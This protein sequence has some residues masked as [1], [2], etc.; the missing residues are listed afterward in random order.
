MLNAFASLKCTKK[1]QHN[2]QKPTHLSISLLICAGLVR[3]LVSFK[4]L[5]TLLRACTPTRT[6]QSGYGEKKRIT[7]NHW[8][9]T[10]PIRRQSSTRN[11]TRCRRDTQACAIEKFLHL[12]S[13]WFLKLQSSGSIPRIRCKPSEIKQTKKTEWKNNHRQSVIER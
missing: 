8:W 1:C 4:S 5:R 6:L 2:V 3:R 9:L 11:K 13:T 12:G 10:Y 7:K